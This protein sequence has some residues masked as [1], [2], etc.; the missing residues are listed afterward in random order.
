VDRG[1]YTPPAESGTRAGE[2]NYAQIVVE[3]QGSGIPPEIL[4]RIFEPFFT[5]KDVG[6]GTGLGLAVSYGIVREHGGWI[7]VTSEVGRGTRFAVHLPVVE[8]PA[9]EKVPLAV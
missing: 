3:D 8:V 5:T 7:A 9:V 1:R 4:P 2:G 6:Q